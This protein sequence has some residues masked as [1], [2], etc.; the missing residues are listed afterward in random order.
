MALKN[1]P[2]SGLVFYLK[3]IRKKERYN[4]FNSTTVLTIISQAKH[5]KTSEL[6]D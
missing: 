5:K 6:G 2:I 3:A 4:K 1:D